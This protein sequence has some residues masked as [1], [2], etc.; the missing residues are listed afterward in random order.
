MMDDARTE[1]KRKRLKPKQ[2]DKRAQPIVRARRDNAVGSDSPIRHERRRHAGR[3]PAPSLNDD[4]LSER[5][6]YRHL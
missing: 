6:D 1:E 4:Q 5:H 2:P 3:R